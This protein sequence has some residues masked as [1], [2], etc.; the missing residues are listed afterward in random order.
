MLEAYHGASAEA[1][2]SATE[3][4]AALGLLRCSASTPETTGDMLSGGSTSESPESN[5]ESASLSKKRRTS[6]DDEWAPEHSGGVNAE[7]GVEPAKSKRARLA[8]AGNP[9]DCRLHDPR[10][11]N[12]AHA[13]LYFG[14]G[15]V[16]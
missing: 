11:P 14:P 5:G 10:N 4:D 8:V 1:V 13:V 3:R 16:V 2:A 7:C 12:D 15:A 6:D 9:C